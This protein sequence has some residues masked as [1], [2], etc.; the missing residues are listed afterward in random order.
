MT[1][2]SPPSSPRPAGLDRDNP[3]PGLAAFTEQEAGFFHG[4]DGEADDL[5]DIV[6]TAGLTVL[7]GNRAG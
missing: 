3:W 2:S 6:R 1:T 5:L 4:R 7:L